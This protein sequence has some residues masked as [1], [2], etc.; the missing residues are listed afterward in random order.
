MKIVSSLILNDYQRTL[1]KDVCPDAEIVC[2]PQPLRN[3]T[4]WEAEVMDP[5]VKDAD[6]MIGHRAREGLVQFAPRLR[7]IQFMGAGIDHL[8]STDLLEQDRIVLTNASGVSA[9]WIA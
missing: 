6:I 2:P 5:L 9:T 4:R 1:I 3:P 7:W 8:G